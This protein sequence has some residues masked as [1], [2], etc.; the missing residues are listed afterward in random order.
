MRQSQTRSLDQHFFLVESC[1]PVLKINV[2]SFSFNLLYQK[3]PFAELSIPKMAFCHLQCTLLRHISFRCPAL[4]IY[5]C[6]AVMQ[7]C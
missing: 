3:N 2:F 1:F 6:R 7:E 4:C 5:A